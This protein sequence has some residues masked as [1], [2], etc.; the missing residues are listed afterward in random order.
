MEGETADVYTYSVETGEIIRLSEGPELLAMNI[1]WSP[2]DQY[3]KYEA[4]R[5]IIEFN[6]GGPIWVVP[7]DGSMSGQLMGENI[8]VWDHFVGWVDDHTIAVNDSSP[9]LFDV[10]TGELTRLYEGEA[11]VAHDPQDD[12][13]LIVPSICDDSQEEFLKL[14]TGELQSISV[15]GCDGANWLDSAGLFVNHRGYGQLTLISPDGEV[16][17][18]TVPVTNPSVPVASDDG[19]YWAWAN[20]CCVFG[21][22]GLWVSTRETNF[23]RLVS[24]AHY[25]WDVMWVPGENTLFFF[26]GDSLYTASAPDFDPVLVSPPGTISSEFLFDEA[27]I[28]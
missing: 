9:K 11:S 15:S 28:P 3:V 5:E 20:A 25:V 2:D 12:V 13:W 27:W 10:A 4:Y 14:P 17:E 22:T 26:V 6:R 1:E 16:S 19:Q 23:K 21:P 7:S 18:L 24:V 8:M